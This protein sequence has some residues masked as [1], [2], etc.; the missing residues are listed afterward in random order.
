MLNNRQPLE[1]LVE[2]QRERIRQLEELLVPDGTRVPKEWG[3]TTKEARVFSHL[4][5]RE[6]ATKQ[7]IMQALYFDLHSDEEPQV[8]IVDVFVCKLRKK[9]K[10]YDVQ[11][12]T[13]WG[14]GY[15]LVDREKYVSLAVPVP[16]E[17]V[18]S[19]LEVLR[20]YIEQGQL[21]EA[22]ASVVDLLH[23]VGEAA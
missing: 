4:T 16:R 5:T 19:L 13:F 10:P 14:Q 22:Q 20:G 11:I 17:D 1:E 9:L 23:L 18:R 6:L 7:T 3:L 2:T 12:E 15:S 8:K 21:E